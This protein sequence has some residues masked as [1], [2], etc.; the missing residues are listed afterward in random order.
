MQTAYFGTRYYRRLTNNAA[1]AAP[2]RIAGGVCLEIVRPDMDDNRA[3][4]N[5][6]GR[7]LVHADAA[8]RQVNGRFSGFV[9]H[10]VP[11][12]AGMPCTGCAVLRLRRVEMPASAHGVGRAAITF[13]MNMKSFYTRRMPRDFP[14]DAHLVANLHKR[15][16]AGNLGAACRTEGDGRRRTA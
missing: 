13:I 10:E 8:Y 7:I 15:E 2:A 6:V 16:V 5:A 14:G 1:R 4:D 9:E 12:V 3:T 11:E